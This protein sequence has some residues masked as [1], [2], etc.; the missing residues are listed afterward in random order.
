MSPPSRK[1]TG[2]QKKQHGSTEKPQAQAP[3]SV[4]APHSPKPLTPSVAPDLAP[5]KQL[6]VERWWDEYSELDGH[7]RL[8]MALDTLEVASREEDW[9]DALFPE[10][11]TELDAELPESEYLALLEQLRDEYPEVFPLGLD[12]HTRSPA[13]SVSAVK[14]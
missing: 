9:F 6:L 5:L 2:K 1:Q 14:S 12:W 4:P 11:I 7:G 3:Q 10:A 8:Q 13:S